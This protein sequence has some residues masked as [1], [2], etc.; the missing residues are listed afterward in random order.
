MRS[1][2][3]GLLLLLM[4]V[5]KDSPAWMC[6]LRDGDAIVSVNEWQITLMDKPEVRNVYF[7]LP[8]LFLNFESPGCSPSPPS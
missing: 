2:E 1:A 4:H 8:Y 6:G 3:S 7:Y 5:T